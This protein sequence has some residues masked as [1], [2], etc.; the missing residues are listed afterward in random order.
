MAITGDGLHVK[1][2]GQVLSDHVFRVPSNQRSYM[3]EEEHVSDYWND[4]IGAMTTPQSSVTQGSHDGNGDDYFIGTIVLSQTDG[5]ELEVVDGQQRLA[6]TTV[7]LAAIR[8]YFM[9]KDRNVSRAR[10]ISDKY[11]IGNN[12]ETLDPEPK[13]SLNDYDNQFFQEN[14]V[15]APAPGGRE[16]PLDRNPK[17]RL[18]DSHRNIA[19]ACRT[20]RTL[21]GF[22]VGGTRADDAE[23]R[24]TKVIRYIRESV[25]VICVTVPNH[26]NAYTIFETLNDRGLDLT[27]ADLLKNHLLRTAKKRVKEA[28]SLWAQMIAGLETVTRNDITVDFIRY[29]W[30]STR[31][32]VRGKELYTKIKEKITQPGLAISFATELAESAGLY[33]AILNSDHPRWNTYGE[34]AKIDL[35]NLIMLGI[36]RIHPIT[37]AVVKSFTKTEEVC[38]ALHYLVAASVRLLIAGPAP[39][40][41]FEKSVAEIAPQISDKKIK[42]ARELAIEMNKDIV[43]ADAEFEANFAVA[44]VSQSHLAKYY[45]RA[46][47]AGHDTQEKFASRVGMESKNNVEH[48]LPL[49]LGGGWHH[50]SEETARVFCKRIGNLTL[51]SPTDNEKVGNKDF[52]SVKVPV[53]AKSDYAITTPLASHSSWG[54]VEI[55]ERQKALAAMAVRIWSTKVT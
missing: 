32:H 43:P 50:I 26:E 33:A 37:L 19:T 51:L 38:K 13:L 18:R 47:N 11:L 4:I 35:S 10:M 52:L 48:I 2:I 27:K 22:Y 28:Q 31:G 36:E 21:I 41:Q 8:D 45:L 39:G 54:P 14:V 1:G 53:Y 7:I 30:I 40:G 44:T 6:T 34:K 12:E 9:E 25:K 16:N 5:D 42:S 15:N 23:K 17:V 49:K 46:L 24:L 55:A 3:W 20:I 29:L